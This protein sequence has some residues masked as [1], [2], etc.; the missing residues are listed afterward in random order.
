M[1]KT[2]EQLLEKVRQKLLSRR[3]HRE[4][5]HGIFPQIAGDK[6]CGY[7]FNDSEQKLEEAAV[8]GGF[9]SQ[10]NID[11]IERRAKELPETYSKAFRYIMYRDLN[12]R[13]KMYLE[14]VR[15]RTPSKVAPVATQPQSAT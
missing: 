10:L 6:N 12:T 5:E 3:L 14:F 1:K 7:P 8:F 15:E 9:D 4:I 2:I 13:I 11:I